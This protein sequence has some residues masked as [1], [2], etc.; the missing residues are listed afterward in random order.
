M[1]FN[2]RARAAKDHHSPSQYQLIMNEE[3]NLKKLINELNFLPLNSQVIPKLLEL[4]YDPKITNQ[5]ITS[6][7]I[8]DPALTAK[9]LKIINSSFYG[10]P[11]EISTISHALVLLGFNGIKNIIMSL[12]VVNYAMK[13]KKQ[14]QDFNSDDFLKHCIATGLISKELSFVTKKTDPEEAFIGGLIHD[15]GKLALLELFQ[16]DYLNLFHQSEQNRISLHELEKQK[17]KFNHCE[18]GKEMSLMWNFPESL[19]NIISSHH[20]KTETMNH[21]LLICQ[22]SN[23]L[24]KEHEIGWSGNNHLDHSTPSL[25]EQLNISENRIDVI[26]QKVQNEL[27]D[28]INLLI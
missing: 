2:V 14:T 16:N 19:V 9:I 23:Q 15:M 4:V 24:T 28:F 22:L 13:L 5:Q 11:R 10:F 21:Q 12:T 8:Q 17:F 3:Q 7:I 25:Y 26:L 20:S 27:E 18:L 6:I 1:I